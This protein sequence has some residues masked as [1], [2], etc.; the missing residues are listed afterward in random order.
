MTTF[1][2]VALFAVVV[3]LAG[4]LRFAQLDLAELKLDEARAL[5]MATKILEEDP[6]VTRGLSTSAGQVNSPA[7][8]YLLA[9][10]L[11]FSSEPVWATGFIAL[12]NTVA[13]AGC[14]LLTRRWFGLAPAFIASLLFALNPWAVIFSPQN[15]GADF[16]AS[17]HGRPAS[18]PVAL[19]TWPAAVVGRHCPPRDGD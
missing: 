1:L 3:V 7:F 9:I 10:P 15:L 12:I 19:S 18:L 11:I 6:F 13:I 5:L 8:L 16:V 4:Y 2:N 14:Y 17:F